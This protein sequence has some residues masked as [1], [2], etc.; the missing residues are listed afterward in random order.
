MAYR[1]SKFTV[2]TAVAVHPRGGHR[3]EDHWLG[4]IEEHL[5]NGK[6]WGLINVRCTDPQGFLN[7]RVDQVTTVEGRTLR[8][9]DSL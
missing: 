2:G 6:P 5:P 9:L 8:R 3:P 4:V 1:P 7:N